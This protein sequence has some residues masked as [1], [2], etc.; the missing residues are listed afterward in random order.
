MPSC[1]IVRVNGDLQDEMISD[2]AI[3]MWMEKFIFLKN[4]G[5]ADLFGLHQE[6]KSNDVNDVVS[7]LCGFTTYGEVLI[8]GMSEDTTMVDVKKEDLVCVLMD[9]MAVDPE[10]KEAEEEEKEYTEDVHAEEEA[11]YDRMDQPDSP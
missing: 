7:Q 11:M 10:K 1:V 5:E 3:S 2:V 6:Q 9:Q 4:V 8:V